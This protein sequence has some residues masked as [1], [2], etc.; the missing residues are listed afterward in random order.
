ML[1][2]ITMLLESNTT[3]KA[4]KQI[5][6]DSINKIESSD[7]LSITDRNQD[8]FHA[9]NGEVIATIKCEAID[10]YTTITYG[11]NQHDVDLND[12]CISNG[13]RFDGSYAI[14]SG[15]AYKSF[16]KLVDINLDDSIDI[17]AYYGN[18][19]YKVADVIYGTTDGSNIFDALGIPQIETAPN[20]DT[21]YL[22][23]CYSFNENNRLL[24]KAIKV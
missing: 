22:Y 23:T 18:F 19:S 4:V 12:V 9:I 21:L 17:H 20:Q 15:H 13:N 8:D 16:S 11:A 7:S 3:N 5:S 10:L 6:E 2:M 14:L 1:F 24:I